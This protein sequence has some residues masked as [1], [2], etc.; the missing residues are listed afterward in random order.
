VNTGRPLEVLD[1]IAQLL[2]R[3]LQATLLSLCGFLIAPALAAS[4]SPLSSAADRL[5]LFVTYVKRSFVGQL[6]LVATTI[7]GAIDVAFAIAGKPGL[8]AWLA[9][10]A[11]LVLLGLVFATTPFLARALLTGSNRGASLLQVAC[12]SAGNRWPIAGAF[13][14]LGLLSVALAF[15]SL[16]LLPLS[17]A[18]YIWALIKL[19]SHTQHKHEQGSSNAR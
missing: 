19:T 15:V 17:A 6:A 11:G 8:L 13:V 16:A 18:V 7:V 12:V 14:I 10:S 3:G 9:L 4:A 1:D 5:R 2:F